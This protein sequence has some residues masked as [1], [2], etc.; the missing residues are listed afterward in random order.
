MTS[1][2]APQVSFIQPT[3]LNKK[4]KNSLPYQVFVFISWSVNHLKACLTSCFA[5]FPYPTHW[6]EN[7]LLLPYNSLSYFCCGLTVLYSLMKTAYRQCYAA[8]YSSFVLLCCYLWCQFPHHHSSNA[9]LSDWL[10]PNVIE[11]SFCELRMW[12]LWPLPWTPRR[13]L[14]SGGHA[15]PWHC[16]LQ[17]L[18]SA[19]PLRRKCKCYSM[20]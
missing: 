17:R 5:F 3:G 20:S 6:P 4:K 11:P 2:R 14:Q 7:L 10:T 1:S 16:S 9:C 12:K 15:I 8:L 18:G 13:M 19:H